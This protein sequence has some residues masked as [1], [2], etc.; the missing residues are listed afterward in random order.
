M[1]RARGVSLAVLLLAGPAM[2]QEQLS[3]R[4]S[5]KEPGEAMRARLQDSLQRFKQ[6]RLAAGALAERTAG[7]VTIPVWVHVINAGSNLSNGNVPDSQIQAQI[8]VLNNSYAGATGGA[9]TPF[10]F[11]LA[12]ITRTTNATWY[13]MAP[14]STEERQAKAALRVGGANTLN[15][16]TANPGG[17]LLGWATFPWSYAGSPSDDG[18]V[19]LYSSLPGGSAV[20]YNEGDTGTHE[21]GHWLGLYHTF[22]GGCAKNGDYVSDTAS[23]KSPAYSCPAG[24]D[25][26]AGRKFPGVDPIEN[27]MDYTDDPC[28]YLFTAGQSSRMDT[29]A[30]QYR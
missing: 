17:G 18:V 14:G 6:N 4:C 29:M 25:S 16:Y 22:Q 8:A 10:T 21:V 19:V 23:E 3:R 13:T 15:V 20:P 27:F 24:R 7:S 26:C 28:M 30:L 12:G 2:A 11:A 9:A 5:T 1:I